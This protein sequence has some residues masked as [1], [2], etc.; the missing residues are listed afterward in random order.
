MHIQSDFPITLCS[1]NCSGAHPK[2]MEWI[3]ACNH[4]QTPAYGSDPVTALARQAFSTLFKKAV[5]VHFVF[6]G[7]AANNLSMLPFAKPHGAVLC[8]E[9]A[10]I[11]M[12]ESTAPERAHGMRL[13]PVAS[14]H[15]KIDPSALEAVLST[16]PSLHSPVPVAIT[17]TQPTEAGTLYSM[18]EL[19]T[20][21]ELAKAKGLG[22][23]VDGA[24]IGCAMAAM[25]V[26][27]ATLLHGVDVLSFG[28][29]KHGILMGEA[30]VF[31]NPTHGKDFPFLQKC[32]MQLASK[33]RFLAAQFA[34]LLEGDLWIA[35]GRHANTKATQLEKTLRALPDIELAYPVETNAV[36]ARLRP[37]RIAKLRDTPFYS[38]WDD[39]GLFRWM[40]A[41]DTREEDIQ[42]L[43][44]ALS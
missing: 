32:S 33:T 1:D 7:T 35:N 22:V 6:N 27:I 9:I 17:L 15:G 14:H 2:V 12:D 5:D 34:G 41:F 24:R 36:F 18:E 4:G 44:A 29:A 39:S 30:V 19:Q 31:L 8:S 25:D 37:E 23:H 21:V 3:L 28:G 40:C 16:A 43:I 26:D 10:H 42:A 11:R 13:I 20:L 38:P